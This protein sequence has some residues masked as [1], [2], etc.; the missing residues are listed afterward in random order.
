MLGLRLCVIHNLRFYNSLMEKI[1]LSLDENRFEEFYKNN[2]E[3]L[4]NRL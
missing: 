3:I 4:G 1:R 2:V